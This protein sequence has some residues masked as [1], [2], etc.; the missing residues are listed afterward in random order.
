MT[1]IAKG[2]LCESNR[3]PDAPNDGSVLVV[4]NGKKSHPRLCVKPLVLHAIPRI[5]HLSDELLAINMKSH[6]CFRSISD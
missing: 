1:V 4:G 6:T 5:L 3:L 2:Y